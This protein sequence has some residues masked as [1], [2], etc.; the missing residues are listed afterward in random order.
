MTCSDYALPMNTILILDK[1]AKTGLSEDFKVR[2]L[3]ILK[4]K[5]HRVEVVELGRKDVTP[6]FGCLFCLT[7]HVGTCVTRDGIAEIR[8]HANRYDMTIFLTPVVFG[9]FGS[10]VKCAI[11]RG[12][13]CQNLQVMVGYGDDIDDEE[14]ST[15]IDLTH[16]HRGKRDIVH[17]GFDKQVDVYL[18]TSSEES[19]SIC[20]AFRKY[21]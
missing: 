6:C 15:F 20:E 16:K 7:K 18:T 21:V 9:H 11:D 13:G 19:R 12:C 4:E 8:N 2:I 1:D 17:P 5:G 10:T 14:K 3:E